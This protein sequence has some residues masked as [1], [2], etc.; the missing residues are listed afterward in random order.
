MTITGDYD[1]DD[2]KVK[3]YFKQMFDNYG[4][5][6]T[7]DP[8]KTTAVSYTHLDVYKRQKL[9][10]GAAVALSILHFIF[11]LDVVAAVVGFC[12]VYGRHKRQKQME[13]ARQQQMPYRD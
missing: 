11:V 7:A 8:D 9:P 5:F 12:T 10:V 1:V 2:Q 3:D 6:Y 4:P 13:A